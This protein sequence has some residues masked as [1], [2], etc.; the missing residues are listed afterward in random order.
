MDVGTIAFSTFEKGKI[1]PFLA[2]S[3]SK[4]IVYQ[5]VE[6]KTLWNQNIIPFSLPPFFDLV[7]GDVSGGSSSASM[8]RFSRDLSCYL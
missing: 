8:V 7:L 6:D 5:V 4:E 3:L 1:L 2:D